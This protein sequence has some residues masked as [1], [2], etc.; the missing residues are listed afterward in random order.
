MK[1][2][3]LYNAMHFTACYLLHAAL[4]LSLLFDS[5]DGSDMFLTFSRTLQT[6]FRLYP[7]KL[8]EA[9]VIFVIVV[10]ALC[11]KLEGHGFETQ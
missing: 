11:Y 9:L 1:S 10:K 7:S 8:M 3:S 6:V 5:E 2:F 4:L